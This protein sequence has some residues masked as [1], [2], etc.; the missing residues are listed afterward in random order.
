MLMYPS[1]IRAGNGTPVRLVLAAPHC[2]PPRTADVKASA[3]AAPALA[4]AALTPRPATRSERRVCRLGTWMATCYSHFNTCHQATNQSFNTYITY[5]P[6]D[7]RCRCC[8]TLA[9]PPRSRCRCRCAGDKHTVQPLWVWSHEICA[10]HLGMCIRSPVRAT[11][12]DLP[13]PCSRVALDTLGF[14]IA[15]I[16]LGV[17]H[18]AWCFERATITRHV[19]GLGLEADMI[20]V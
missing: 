14:M 20:R 19:V 1:A 3:A 17:A 9:H 18:W 6:L 8:H 11:S 13:Q 15:A 5:S 12:V 4:A 16:Q 7:S 2:P 10:R